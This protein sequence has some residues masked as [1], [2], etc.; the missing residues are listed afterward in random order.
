M[1]SRKR[2]KGKAR[3]AKK[4]ILFQHGPHECTHGCCEILS[5]ND[6]CYRFL[7][8]LE[9]EA[10]SLY[11]HH[12][13]TKTDL[14]IGSAYTATITRLIECNQFTEIFNDEATRKMLLPCLL[15]AGTDCLLKD[16]EYGYMLASVVAVTALFCQH[17]FHEDEIL[18]S[19]DMGI[20]RDLFQGSLGY[21]VIKF[22]AK[23]IPCNCLKE[24]YSLSKSEPKLM[25]CCHCKETKERKYLYLCGGCMH[26]HYCS[27]E[28]QKADY[29]VHCSCCKKHGGRKIAG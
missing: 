3:K 11:V 9:R 1:P 22:F 25:T 15:G 4:N 16:K 10:H 14:T 29:S 2:A 24:M 8:Q 20:Y 5:D 26:M 27:V 19:K 23:R 18:A 28:C 13:K 6:V 17:N 7:V 12:R 21:D